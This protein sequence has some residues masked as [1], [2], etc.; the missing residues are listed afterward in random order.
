MEHVLVTGTTCSIYR[1]TDAGLILMRSLMDFL[2]GLH[3]NG[4]C[5]SPFT[6]LTLDN[7][8]IWN[9][10]KICIQVEYIKLISLVRN[11]GE[12]TILASQVKSGCA[13]GVSADYM[14][15]LLLFKDLLKH[16]NSTFI[17]QQLLGD[18]R[19]WFNEMKTCRSIWGWL[20]SS[21]PHI[22]AAHEQHVRCVSKILKPPHKSSHRQNKKGSSLY[23]SSKL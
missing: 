23:P 19:W 1:A 6:P 11:E 2:S 17:I 3:N 21:S 22:Y 16:S 14:N 9:E 12:A 10:G 18:M 5:I 15:A 20:S 8:A 7:I 4:C 13:S